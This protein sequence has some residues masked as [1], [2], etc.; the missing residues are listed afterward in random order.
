MFVVNPYSG[1]K[2]NVFLSCSNYA[3]SNE[4]ALSLWCEDGP[5][6][7]LTVASGAKCDP[8]TAYIDTNN[9]PWA[10]EF[11]KKYGIGR[12]IIGFLQS[13]FCSYPKY[14]LD[15]DRIKFLINNPDWEPEDEEFSDEQLARVDAVY[16]EVGKLMEFLTKEDGFDISQIGP[17]AEEIAEFLTAM[18]FDVYF[19]TQSEYGIT[20]IYPED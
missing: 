14:R 18:G 20:D 19:P 12:P 10:S 8:E 7:T 5:Y 4:N 15:M 13:G 17:V 2:Y 11:L 6:A 9:C 3:A 1:E 16:E